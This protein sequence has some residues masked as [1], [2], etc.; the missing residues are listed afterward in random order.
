MTTQ[1]KINDAAKAREYFEAKMAF[2]TGPVEVNRK[3]SITFTQPA[4][5]RMTHLLRRRRALREAGLDPDMAEVRPAQMVE[6]Y[7]Q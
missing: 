7:E 4:V 3:V 6:N 2:T 5:S 1:A